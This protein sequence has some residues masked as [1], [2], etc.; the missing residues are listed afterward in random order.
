MKI[1][2]GMVVHQIDDKSRV[3]VPTKFFPES[4]G[5]EVDEKEDRSGVRFSM[6]VGPQGSINV[7]E[8]AVLD[9]WLVK[10]ME[11]QEN[12]EDGLDSIR[13]IFSSV[14]RVETDKQGRIIIPP[15][16]KTYAKI[17]KEVVSVG[18]FDHFEIWSKDKYE[19]RNSEITYESAFKRIG[20]K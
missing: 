7:Y 18:I 17:T 20:Y 12:S 4:G 15:Q 11:E 6:I 13:K 14:E 16:L 1:L 2:S 3:R 19:E 9:R 10:K 5:K 8:E